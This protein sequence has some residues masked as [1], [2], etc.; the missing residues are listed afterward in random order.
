[1]RGI[2]QYLV[3]A[4]MFQNSKIQENNYHGLL[5]TGIPC[6]RCISHK[7]YLAHGNSK[8]EIKGSSRHQNPIVI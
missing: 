7:G 4:K 6:P 2:K 3:A 8:G 1:M 5:G